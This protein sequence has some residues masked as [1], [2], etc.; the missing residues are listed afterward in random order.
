MRRIGLFVVSLA[1]WYLVSWPY[2][3]VSHIMDWQ[4]FIVGVVFSVIASV[5]FVDVF[6]KSPRK[7]LSPSR[8][9]WALCYLPVL[10]YY[11]V[12][13]NLDVLYRVVHPSMPIRPGIV[14]VRT[15]LTSESG[16]AALANSITLTP[17]T[18]SVDITDDGFLY[19]HW[20]YVRATEM[21]EATRRIVS[22]FERFLVKIFD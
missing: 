14:K 5:L 16:R 10:F 22:R 4:I 19:V 8:Y 17:G 12:I 3:F 1:I 20:I 21:E 6:T 7:L 11:M 2:D 9:F 18:L 15:R 13:A